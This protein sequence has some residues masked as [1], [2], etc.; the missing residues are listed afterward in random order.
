MRLMQASPNQL[1]TRD[2]L[3]FTAWG[4][5]LT[6]EQF[7][8]REDALRAHRWSRDAMESWLWVDA[9]GGVLSSCETFRMSSDVGGQ[10][11]VT[12]GVASVFTEAGLRRRGHAEAMVDAVKARLLQHEPRVQALVLFSEIGPHL[13]E[14][15][16]FRAVPS[17]D[18]TYAPR[19]GD[20][21]K[22]VNFV[23]EL[24]HF[25]QSML[26]LPARP[27]TLRVHFSLDQL[28][29][30][31][32]RERFYARELGA[33]PLSSCGATSGRAAIA[34]TA[35]FKSHE[36]H[37]LFLRGDPRDYEPLIAAARGVAA[38]HQLKVVRVWE[39]EPEALRDVPDGVRTPREDVPMFCPMGGTAIEQWQPVERA[40]WV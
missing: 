40:V 19:Q 39:N 28:D 9:S 6:V 24:N 13:Y 3:C 27:G 15:V 4:G 17:Y 10:G 5:R 32:E 38:A 29:W 2:A 35:S 8:R 1:A 37:V 30:H 7:G 22:G 12:Y 18:V 23:R 21:R 16:G 26:M 14:R 36:L 11:G 34:W 31:R 25:D 33:T 20:A